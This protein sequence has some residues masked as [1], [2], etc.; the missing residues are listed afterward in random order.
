MPT[1][2]HPADDATE[3]RPVG[4][5]IVPSAVLRDPSLSRDARLLYA[6]LDGRAGTKG[7]VRVLLDT[8]AADLAASPASVRR[9]L[10]ELKS[11]GLITTKVTGRSLA[12]TVANGS[13]SVDKRPR[14]LTRDRSECSPVSALQSNNKREVTTSRAES[15]KPV[16]TI[17]A[18]AG[19][20]GGTRTYLAAVESATG[21]RLRP[22][23]AVREHLASIRQQGVTPADLGTLTAAYLA[24]HGSNVE[25]PAGWLAG[26]VLPAIADGQRPERRPASSSPTM[27]ADVPT[28]RP[29]DHGEPRGESYCALCRKSPRTPQKRSTGQ[30]RDPQTLADIVA[31]LAQGKP[32]IPA[33]A[34]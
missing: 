27:Y 5:A 33:V 11:A 17:P 7:S 3:I 6:V 1:V 29:C 18:T 21:H 31:H 20:D 25:S 15:E 10:A 12:I 24:A 4:Y 30:S 8:L 2:T 9:Y 32:G 26:F 14:S 13:R 23:T 19:D 16:P 22:T 34:A 28:D